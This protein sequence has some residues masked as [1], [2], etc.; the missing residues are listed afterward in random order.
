MDGI[1]FAVV[2]LGQLSSCSP[3]QR[4]AR[5][6]APHLYGFT[7]AVPLVPLTAGNSWR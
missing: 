3:I 2:G 6:D 7:K 5:S 1:V 4:R